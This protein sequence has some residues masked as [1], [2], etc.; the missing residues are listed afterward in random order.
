MSELLLQ[1]EL[2]AKPRELGAAACAGCAFAQLGCPKQ[3]S[4]DCPPP[5]VIES[6]LATTLLNDDAASEVWATPNGTFRA[7]ISPLTEPKPKEALSAIQSIHIE[8]GRIVIVKT[9][10]STKNERAPKLKGQPLGDFAASVLLSA[11]RAK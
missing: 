3:G 9:D 1:K 10:K 8:Q 5:Q 6:K 7:T 4:G 2:L 11:K